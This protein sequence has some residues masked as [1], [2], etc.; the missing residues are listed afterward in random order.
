MAEQSFAV[1]GLHCGGCVQTITTALT[2][3]R[4]VTAVRVDLN[5]EGT[6]TVHVSTNTELTREQVQAALNGEGNFSVVG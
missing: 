4:P 5:A 1:N 6:S 2:E 3:L